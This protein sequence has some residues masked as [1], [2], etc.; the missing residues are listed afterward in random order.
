MFTPVGT[1][2]FEALLL[3]ENRNIITIEVYLLT[4][5]PDSVEPFHVSLSQM[6]RNLLVTVTLDEVLNLND[7]S[8][9]YNFYIVY[10]AA[11]HTPSIEG[12]PVGYRYS[13]GSVSVILHEIGKLQN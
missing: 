11:T 6:S 5:Y 13:N 1:V 9:D 7:D 4:S 3:L 2:L 8:I 10:I 12:T